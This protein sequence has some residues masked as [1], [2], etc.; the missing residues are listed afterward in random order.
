M[1]KRFSRISLSVCLSLLFI[2]FS[3]NI[4][5]NLSPFRTR[6]AN[7]VENRVN[8]QVEVDYLFLNW[9]LQPVLQN[10]TVNRSSRDRTN[11]SFIELNDIT[12]SLRWR[13]L[14]QGPRTSPRELV[15]DIVVGQA[16]L[17]G[18]ASEALSGKGFRGSLPNFP[19]NIN[20]WLVHFSHRG[21]DVLSLEGNK[22]S[23]QS[24]DKLIKS[25]LSRYQN[26]S[27]Q[28]RLKLRRT[29]AGWRGKVDIEKISLSDDLWK[30]TNDRWNGTVGLET[31]GDSG[32]VNFSLE[33]IPGQIANR[34]LPKTHLESRVVFGPGP[35]N[36]ENLSVSSDVLRSS[37]EG[38]FS[39]SENTIDLA[40][41]FQANLSDK[42][43]KMSNSE[44]RFSPS[45]RLGGQL[46]INGN[47]FNP[48]LKG[49]IDFP[50]GLI[51]IDT[52]SGTETVRISSVSGGINGNRIELSGGKM[53][54][55]AQTFFIENGFLELNNGRITSSLTGKLVRNS[56]ADTENLV[57]GDRLKFLNRTSDVNLPMNF[58]STLGPETME[59]AVAVT[60]GSID[61]GPGQ[62]TGIEGLVSYAPGNLSESTIKGRLKD[63]DG[64]P[65]HITGTLGGN[66]YFRGNPKRFDRWLNFYFPGIATYLDMQFDEITV[67]G[68]ITSLKDLNDFKFGISHDKN[69]TVRLNG[70][71]LSFG[72]KIIGD[73]QKISLNPL[74][75]GSKKNSAKVIGEISFDR[76]FKKNKANLSAEFDNFNLGPFFGK[77]VDYLD[78]RLSGNMDIEGPLSRPTTSGT[79]RNTRLGYK[80]LL[81]DKF[82]A[83]MKSKGDTIEFRSIK[84]K[85]ASGE[86]TGKIEVKNLKKLHTSLKYD[87][88]AVEKLFPDG[89]W[90]SQ[91]SRAKLH[92]NLD[93]NGEFKDVET[94]NGQ[95]SGR[96]DQFLL[97]RFPQIKGIESVARPEILSEPIVVDPFDF[98][99]PINDG[100]IR[101]NKTVMRSPDMRLTIDGSIP[102]DGDLN[103]KL[104]LTLF[105][106][107]LKGFLQDVVGDFYRG[108]GLT[109]SEKKLTIPMVVHGSIESPEL[110]VRK[111]ELSGNFRENI[112]EDLFSEPIGKPI[113][114]LLDEIF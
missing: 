39:L 69:S 95:I 9:Q 53:F 76:Q 34:D 62:F 96:F 35:F 82:S 32:S 1:F 83:D 13:R 3:L 70:S 28:A 5:L 94:W 15:S 19:V 27:A 57:A 64:N 81:L 7:F 23:Y 26:N 77:Y 43:N 80:S 12:L 46:R 37:L 98:D 21:D 10:L 101:V 41:T 103:L 38:G 84:G 6:I 55:L 40:G 113:N 73:E 106:D 2:Y 45:D 48:D 11:T 93:I 24:Q 20:H 85:T 49:D 107:A 91:N 59:S 33:G 92:A 110:V 17:T 58:S 29:Q 67:K 79:L 30:L 100:V 4:A 25:V 18:P 88:I 97:D 16:V 72:G 56:A 63:P 42:I 61:Y 90:M 54:Q 50:G 78:F 99:Y 65:W 68:R 89:S 112:V 75:L 114:E 22:L 44:V 108:I 86:V 109:S 31:T 87:D 47:L 102:L 74:R 51:T 36:V 104:D 105:D 14:F 111:S 52:S 60:G 8:G 71:S 66:K